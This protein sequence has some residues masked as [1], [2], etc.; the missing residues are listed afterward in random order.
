MNQFINGAD[1]H[2]YKFFSLLHPIIEENLKST[3]YNTHSS[4]IG[5]MTNMIAYH[6]GWEGEGAGD[7]AQGKRIRPLIVLLSTAA[8]GG[9]WE[10][11]LPAAESVELI[12][13]FSLIHDDIEDGSDLRRGRPTVW[14]IWGTSQA[15]NSGDALFAL[16]FQTL[17]KLTNTATQEITIN[18]F[19]ILSNTC[20]MLTQGQYLD[21]SYEQRR[22]LNIDD[23]WLMVKGKTAALIAACAEMGALIGGANQNLREEF[24]RFGNLL[25]LA[26]QVQDDYLGIWGKSELTGKSTKSD[27]VTGKNTLPVLY[28]LDKSDSFA[29]RWCQAPISADEVPEIVL[30]LEGAGVREYTQE[31]ADQLSTDALDALTK[32]NPK[33]EAGQALI[34]LTN[35]LLLRQV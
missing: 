20:L 22:N 5:D 24:R 10:S 18:A 32:A 29:K 13:N 15:I 8:V 31:I 23:Y 19:E 27:L 26:F 1:K 34:E 17:T 3:V 12:H 14:K 28:G 33:G 21:L 35:K 9:S 2:I 11:T 7:T 4:L 25:G 30:L 6:M 16:A